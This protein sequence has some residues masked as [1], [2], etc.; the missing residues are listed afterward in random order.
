VPFSTHPRPAHLQPSTNTLHALGNSSPSFIF[1]T[2]QNTKTNASRPVDPHRDP[3]PPHSYAPNHPHAQFPPHNNANP[4]INSNS[5]SN[6]NN[7][8]NDSPIAILHPNAPTYHTWNEPGSAITLNLNRHGKPLTYSLAKAGPDRIRLIQAEVE[9]ITRF[10]LS[11]T[12][13]P[14]AFSA[15]AGNHLG[16]IVYYNPV[17]K[18]NSKTMDRSNF[19]LEVLQAEIYLTYPM[20]SPRELQ[21]WMSSNYCCSPLYL[22]ERNGSLSI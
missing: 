13:I 8:S 21:A 15:I 6:V 16:D 1:Q 18:Q 20:T 4:N 17:V 11:G 14:I 7:N 12:I 3:I 9:E 10:I 5:N 22:R 2:H 19:A